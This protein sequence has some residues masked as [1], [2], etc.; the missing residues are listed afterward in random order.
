MIEAI[1]FDFNG[2]LYFDQ[3]INYITW[4]ETI[5]AISNSTINFKDFFETHFSVMNSII[6][7]D[8]YKLINKPCTP[9]DIEYWTNYKENR[10]RQYGIDHKTTKLAPG[11]E[12]LL[13]YLKNRN[14]PV[15]LCTSSILDNVN[16]YYDYFGLDNWFNRSQTVYDT[17]EYTSKSEMYK[18]CAKRLNVNISNV[19]VFEDSPSSIKQAIQAGV[20]KLIVI[21]KNNTP[22]LPQIKQ[23]I[24]DYTQVDYSIFE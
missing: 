21:Q 16:Y 8:A 14:I 18:E 1:F 10:Y 4:E 12:N 24:K 5:N 3:E 19:I 11:A 13:N 6:I 2:T 9:E 17:G 22:N 20:T 15:I 23:K 7:K